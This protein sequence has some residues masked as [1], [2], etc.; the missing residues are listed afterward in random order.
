ME[1]GE[2][3]DQDTILERVRG[4]LA[5]AQDTEFEPEAAALFAK[6]QE[7]MTKYAIDEAMVWSKLNKGSRE[8]PEFARILVTHLVD[9]IRSRDLLFRVAEFNNLKAVMLGKQEI[10]DKD[11]RKGYAVGLVGFPTDLQFTE[12]MWTSLLLQVAGAEKRA[13]REDPSSGKRGA[14]RRSFMEGFVG[15]VALRLRDAARAA[16]VEADKASA[17]STA[18][19]LR[20]RGLEV[21]DKF[22]ELFPRL[23]FSRQTRRSGYDPSAHFR[24]GLA[25]ERADLGRGTGNAGGGAKELGR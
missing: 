3:A 11:G 2:M 22:K 16:T 23:V 24:G 25:G 13:W 5:K 4:L 19:V 21:D 14:F 18:L 20:D 9:G 6:A 17:G 10:K 15:R 7:L 1:D 12:M 8:T